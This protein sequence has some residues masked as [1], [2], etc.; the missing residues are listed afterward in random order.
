MTGFASQRDLSISIFVNIV[1]KQLFST[2]FTRSTYFE[3]HV[4]AKTP[5]PE[6][7]DYYSVAIRKSLRQVRVRLCSLGGRDATYVTVL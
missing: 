3:Q 7:E 6:Q 5:P 2:Y 4:S 1:V